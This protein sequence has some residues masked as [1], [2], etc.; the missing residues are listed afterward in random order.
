[1]Q[2]YSPDSQPILGPI[3]LLPQKGSVSGGSKRPLNSFAVLRDGYSILFDAPVSW[4]LDGIARLADGGRPPRALVLS[5]RNLC[6]SGDAFAEIVERY[7]C[8]VLLHPADQTHPEA[9]EAGVAFGD[10]T[11]DPVLAD[12]GVEAV[13][14]PGHTDGS[15]VLHLA[16]E[17]GIVLAGDCAVGPGPEQSDRTRRLERPLG[18]A[19]GSDFVES[20]K[21]IVERLPI[22]AV[23]PLHG[24]GYLRRDVGDEAFDRIVRNIWAGEPMDPRRA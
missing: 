22:A 10:P 19:D 11:T 24:E 9:G 16:D 18:A 20:W 12:A 2:F 3:V 17:G 15:I 21:G 7:G 6:S 23:L 8:P 1:M 13:H 4:A 14:V 5:H